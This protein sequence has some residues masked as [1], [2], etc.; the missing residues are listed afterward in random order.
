[1]KMKIDYY[2]NTD[3][4]RVRKG[5]EDYFAGE[6]IS[7]REYIF[8]V[9][10]GMGGHQAG[11]VASKLGTVTFIDRYAGQREKQKSIPATLKNS[12]EAANAAILEKGAMEKDKRG[13]GTT[14]TAFAI[15]NMQGC[16]AHVGDSRLYVIRNNAISQ[17]T[18]D[19]TFVGKMVE[20][21]KLSMDEARDHPQKNILY[22]SLGARH[23]FAPDISETFEVKE[24]DT[25]IMCSDGL[26]NMMTDE[27]IKEVCMAH[28]PK[29]AVDKLIKQ[30]N[31][32]GGMDNITALIVSV[33]ESRRTEETEP[34]IIIKKNPITSFFAKFRRE[35]IK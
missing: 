32:N 28:R 27:E 9:A 19:H 16:F 2:G 17:L 26:N 21:G 13:M 14:F 20:E 11:N 33:D 22:M 5:N 24:G 29:N 15:E 23:S 6:K 34:L 7:D 10:D 12:I 1:M 35:G 30:A 8:V 31:R 18:K 4:G 3:K 25:Y